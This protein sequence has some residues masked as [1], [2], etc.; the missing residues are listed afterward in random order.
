MIV[1]EDAL[2]TNNYGPD[3]A[4]SRPDFRCNKSRKGSWVDNSVEIRCLH[5]RMNHMPNKTRSCFPG[6]LDERSAET[7]SCN[8]S[9]GAS[10]NGITNKSWIP[11]E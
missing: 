1:E 9:S 4:W 11:R 7:L 3:M 5:A 2:A 10:S 8:Y 6:W